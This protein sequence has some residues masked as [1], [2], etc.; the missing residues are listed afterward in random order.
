MPNFKLKGVPTGSRMRVT[1]QTGAAAARGHLLQQAAAERRQPTPGSRTHA[2]EL[3]SFSA[4]VGL[5]SCREFD[6]QYT[7]SPSQQLGRLRLRWDARLCAAVLLL[8]H[9]QDADGQ[10]TGVRVPSGPTI[11]QFNR[12][13]CSPALDS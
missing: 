3:R 13:L 4:G 5:G 9:H 2:A 10:L 12:G 11:H 8:I 7:A 6:Y 1:A